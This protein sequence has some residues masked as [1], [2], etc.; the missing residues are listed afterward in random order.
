MA[1]VFKVPVA[2]ATLGAVEKGVLRLEEEIEIREADR[3]EIGPLY[4]EWKPGMRVTVARMIDVMLVN[5]DNTAADLLIRLVGGPAA[6]EK[7]LVAKRVPGI[8][9]S[10]DEKGMGAAAKKDR[11]AFEKGAQNG[12]SPDAMAAFLA[13]LHK[14]ELLSREATDRVLGAMRR[15]ATGDR[16]LRAGLPKGTEVADK[17]GTAGSCANDAGIITLPDGSHLAVAVFVRGG[18]D[19]AAREGAI[20]FVAKAAWEAFAP[21][22]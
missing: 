8:R 16:R 4:D 19:A 1:S 11:V 7:V 5:S 13:R 14:G 9:I 18:K 10:L 12:A 20:A 22:R 3:R 2:I 17:T 15:C 6:V 21:T